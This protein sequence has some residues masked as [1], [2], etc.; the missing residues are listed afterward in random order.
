MAATF[1]K[2]QGYEMGCSLV[3][4]ERVALARDILKSAQAQDIA[5]HLPRDLVV[6]W[7][8][9]ADA[10]YETVAADQVPKDGYAMDIGPATVKTFARE[11]RKCRTILWNGPMGV[12]EFEPFT[13]GTRAIA[14]T[15]A[16][17]SGAITVVGGGST[18]EAVEE[19][20]LTNSMNHVSTGG[21]A[22]LE[23]LEGRDLPGVST[24]P[25]KEE[26]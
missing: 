16:D 17:L 10:P 9:A 1:F 5:V 20:G 18:A 24:L 12:F 14:E 23:F 11:L 7:T 19:M 26:R 15:L 25:D 2:A 21:G 4:E 3:E 8:F 6:T 22:S 13:N